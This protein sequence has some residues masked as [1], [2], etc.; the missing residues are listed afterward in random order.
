MTVKRLALIVLLFSSIGSEAIGQGG[1]AIRYIPDSLLKNANAVFQLDKTEIKI[2]SNKKTIEEKH[3]VITILNNKGKKFAELYEGY[4]KH[5]KV[6][7]ISARVL[8]ANGN[9]VRTFYSYDFDDYSNVSGGTIFD[10]SRIKYLDVSQPSFPYTVEFKSEV[11][12][13]SLFYIPNW[14]AVPDENVSVVHSIYN[15]SSPTELKPRYKFLNTDL[16]LKESTEDGMSFMSLF[17]ENQKATKR[18]P[19]GPAFFETV[20]KLLLAPSEMYFDGFDGNMESWKNYGLWQL[21]LNQGRDSLSSKSINE[22]RQITDQFE[23]REDKIRAVYEYVQNKTRYVSIQLGIGGWQPYEATSVDELGYGDCKALSNYTYS[24]LKSV[25][26]NSYYTKV[27][28]GSNPPKLFDDFPYMASNHIILCVPNDQDTVWLECTSQ[29]NPFGY[30]GEFTGDREVMIVTQDGGKIVRTP[31]YS[32]EDNRQIT[33]A[34][35]DISKDGHAT[36]TVDIQYTGTQYENN[37]LNWVI[38]DGEE[39][40]KKWIYNNTDIPEFQVDDFSFNLKKDKIPSIDEHIEITIRSMASVNG[41][42]FFVRP[43]MMNRWK[44]APRRISNRQTEVVLSSAFY[45]SDSL[46][47]KIPENLHIEYLPEDIAISNEFGKYNVSFE[48]NNRELIYVR[49]LR[50]NKGTF[51][52]ESYDKF[53]NFYRAIV[54]GDKAKVVFVDKT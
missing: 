6:K 5:S 36:A 10:D 46:V 31:S 26:I 20:P 35:I 9:E 30:L 34:K 42:R 37:D 15:L 24:L 7:S 4:D 38:N 33:R 50:W 48:Y 25:G 2:L 21:K 49:Q 44:K 54:K 22:I 17:V 1:Y 3:Q 16:E 23:S 45:D 28:A 40:L 32:V 53:R 18:E 13:Q 19:Y 29:T 41:E 27:Y 52:K 8:D 12:Y 39:K 43:N 51:P 11:V 14:Y 47:Y